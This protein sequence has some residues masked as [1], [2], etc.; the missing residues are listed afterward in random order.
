LLHTEGLSVHPLDEAPTVVLKEDD[1][2]LATQGLPLVAPLFP[3]SQGLVLG[4]VEDYR[5]FA[6]QP[7]HESFLEH[8]LHVVAPGQGKGATR[9]SRSCM[10]NRCSISQEVSLCACKV[11]AFPVQEFRPVG[12]SKL[13]S[14]T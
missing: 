5:R 2:H 10:S 14:T 4:D 13:K 9:T 8:R 12:T 11:E 1:G 7:V 6:G 3:A